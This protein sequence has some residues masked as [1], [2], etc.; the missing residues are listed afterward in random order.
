MPRCAVEMLFR[1]G[2][3]EVAER[4]PLDELSAGGIHLAQA[5]ALGKQCRAVRPDPRVS[6]LTK[7]GDT[8]REKE[9]ESVGERGEVPRKG[10]KGGHLANLVASERVLRWSHSVRFEGSGLEGVKL[11]RL[12][13]CSPGGKG[14]EEKH[15]DQ[16]ESGGKGL[17]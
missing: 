5:L 4:P 15:E 10:G 12:L 7:R 17:L 6:L 14:Q 16:A 8:Q 11:D 9:R 2:E 13:E 1:D 3:I